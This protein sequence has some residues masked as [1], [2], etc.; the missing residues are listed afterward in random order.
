MTSA[1][2][3]TATNLGTGRST[4]AYQANK[5]ELFMAIRGQALPILITCLYTWPMSF[6]LTGDY[7][8]NLDLRKS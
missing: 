7:F 2:D 3:S 8:R 6:P 5:A 4:K 1:A